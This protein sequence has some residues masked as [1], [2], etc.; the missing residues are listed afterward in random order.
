MPGFRPFIRLYVGRILLEPVPHIAGLPLFEVLAYPLA[1]G[2]TIVSLG[3][4]LGRFAGTDSKGDEKVKISSSYAAFLTIPVFFIAGRILSYNLL[5]IYSSY[6]ARQFDTILWAAATGLWISIM[7]LLLKPGI[8]VKSPLL[9][10]IY[11]AVVIY[12]IDYFLFNLFMPLVFDYQIWPVGTLLSYAD[13]FV[14]LRWIFY[15][16]QQAY[17]SPRRHLKYN[18]KN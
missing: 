4:L 15:P 8:S 7:Y 12:G 6:A 3:V 17:I 5:H 18:K 2:I 1:D 11:F 16:W 9:K 13:L 14:R 10:A